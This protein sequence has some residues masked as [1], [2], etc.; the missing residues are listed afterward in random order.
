MDAKHNWR[1]LNSLRSTESK[2]KQ[3]AVCDKA[4]LNE[5]LYW[6]S[7]YQIIAVC[8]VKMYVAGRQKETLSY[9]LTEL[10]LVFLSLSLS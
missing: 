6:I 2:V 8:Y 5:F 1:W 9:D 4:V 10:F 3:K 7:K